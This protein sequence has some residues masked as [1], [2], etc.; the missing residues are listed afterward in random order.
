M[1]SDCVFLSLQTGLGIRSRDADVVAGDSDE[2]EEKTLFSYKSK[3]KAVSESCHS[4]LCLYNNSL[5]SFVVNFIPF[6]L[7]PSQ[8]REGPAD[9]GATATLE[10][11]TAQDRDARAI[12]EKSKKMNQVI[13]TYSVLTQC[14]MLFIC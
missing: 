3:K 8:E 10:S 14:I 6:S 7:L 1:C 4:N 11:E 12:F 9:L 13:S 5:H 2:E